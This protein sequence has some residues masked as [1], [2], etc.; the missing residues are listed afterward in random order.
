MFQNEN[1]ARLWQAKEETWQAYEFLIQSEISSANR[2]ARLQCYPDEMPVRLYPTS[3]FTAEQLPFYSFFVNM[4]VQTGLP[5]F[6][7][8]TFAGSANSV[9]FLQV[10]AAMRVENLCVP[11]DVREQ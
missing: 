4:L 6:I 10:I 8:H 3:Q 1:F 7:C 11:L 9:H 2:M 5:I